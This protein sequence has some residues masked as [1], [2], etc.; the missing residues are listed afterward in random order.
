ML[1][2]LDGLRS[3]VDAHF[4]PFER[5]P[6]GKYFEQ[7]LFYIL[8]RDE[9][10][11]VL[12]KNHQVMRGIETIG[13]IDLI[14]KDVVTGEIEHWEMALKYYLQTTASSDHSFMVGP[15][16]KDDLSKKMKK[17]TDHQLPLTMDLTTLG[18]SH[19]Q[20]IRDRLYLKGQFFYHFSYKTGCYIIPN[21]ANPMHE[22]GWWCHLSEV[23]KCL[24]QNLTWIIIGK[25]EWIGHSPLSENHKQLNYNDICDSLK[26]HF[27]LN[28]S[29]RLC[30]GST[31]MNGIW[32]EQVRVFVVKNDW[33]STQKK[34]LKL[35]GMD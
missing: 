15:N 32:K 5:L 28:D 14:L 24:D 6:M 9:R 31:P 17:L 20:Q 12:V 34:D 8:E 3:E 30:V 11:E 23:E 10:F 22:R 35:C 18:I 2:R 7:L 1:Q 4:A 29:A 13:E 33:P 25:P 27:N 16:V 19:T 26:Q 21:G